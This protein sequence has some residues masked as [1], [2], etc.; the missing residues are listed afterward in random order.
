M[1]LNWS[2]SPSSSSPVLI[3]MRW[4][5]SPL[6]MR[7]APARSAWIGPTMRRAREKAERKGKT[8]AEDTDAA[9]EQERAR[10]LD[11]DVERRIGLVD[12]QLGE[13]QP[14]DRRHRRI[15]GQHFATLD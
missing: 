1:S 8:K 11:R 9:Q 7:A 10:A 12:R 6:P 15:G 2:A 13:H 4:P 5:R 3:E 14:A